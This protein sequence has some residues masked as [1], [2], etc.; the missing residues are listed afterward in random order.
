MSIPQGDFG[1]AVLQMN[2][3]DALQVDEFAPMNANK[4]VTG[5]ALPEC[6]EA[7]IEHKLGILVAEQCVSIG[8]VEAA[9][10]AGVEHANGLAGARCDAWGFLVA[11]VGEG[12]FQERR[13]AL[14]VHRGALA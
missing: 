11:G 5:E 4:T 3:L 6:I 1:R 14:R 9:D 7:L 10:R 12:T 8:S 13:Q 2:G